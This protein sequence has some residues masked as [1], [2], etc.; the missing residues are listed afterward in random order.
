MYIRTLSLCTQ[1]EGSSQSNQLACSPFCVRLR[2]YALNT[3]SIDTLGYK[4]RAYKSRK[5]L[6]LYV[7]LAPLDP[8]GT[9]VTLVIGPIPEHC[10]FQYLL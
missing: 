7:S 5:C 3:R 10:T 9:L 6:Q 1:R 4:F 2:A 8:L